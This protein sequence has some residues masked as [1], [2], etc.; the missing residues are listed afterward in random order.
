M[1]KDSIK[2]K[3]VCKGD[4]GSFEYGIW[5][6][7]MKSVTLTVIVIYRPPYSQVH[8][9][10]VNTFLTDFAEFLT[11]VTSQHSNILIAGDFNIHLNDNLSCETAAYTEL[12]QAFGFDQHVEKFTHKAGNILDH[13]FTEEASEI[14]V[15]RCENKD[16]ISDH[17]VIQ[18]D[19]KVPKENIIRKT[20]KYRKFSKVDRENLKDD[21]SLD[22]Y[23]S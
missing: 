2:I 4:K 9:V 23:V 22:P 15:T 20:V 17:C 1:Y 11:N 14:R 21:L 13:I 7:S 19:I 10:T 18:C 16:F 3:V 12:M 5:K 8:P 6:A